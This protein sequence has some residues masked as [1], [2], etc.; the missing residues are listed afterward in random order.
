MSKGII[1][2]TNI[3]IMGWY[4]SPIAQAISE[5]APAFT[6]NRVTV[7]DDYAWYPLSDCLRV[8]HTLA[9][10]AMLDMANLG[11]RA[12]KHLAIPHWIDTIPAALINLEDT[13]RR[14]HRNNHHGELSARIITARQVRCTVNTPYPED[15]M[16]GL[17]SGVAMRYM[18]SGSHFEVRRSYADRAAV[19]DVRW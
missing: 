1:A 13:Y 9:S 4:L 3:E 10:E 12:A 6:K 18:P 5:I 8:L 11:M 7:L 15:F 19:I 2:V 17:I 14:A 16:Y